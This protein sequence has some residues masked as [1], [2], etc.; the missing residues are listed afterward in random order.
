MEK[1]FNWKAKRYT[2]LK[3]LEKAKIFAITSRDSI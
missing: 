3:Y 2:M 1:C